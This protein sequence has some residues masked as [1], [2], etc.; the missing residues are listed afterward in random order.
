MEEALALLA[1][2]DRQLDT[3][4]DFVEWAHAEW[5]EPSDAARVRAT[6]IVDN[7]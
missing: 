2:R 6:E 4:A 1:Q 3:M 7:R 5:G